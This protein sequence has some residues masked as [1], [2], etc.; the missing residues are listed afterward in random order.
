MAIISATEVGT[1]RQDL[2]SA[3]V[4]ETLKLN[5]K[6]IGLVMD[7]STSVPAGAKS[8]Y[9]P[10]RGQFAAADKVEDTDLTAQAFTF[11]Q[12]QLTLSHKA[13]L[14][15]MELIADLQSAVNVE[16]EIIKESAMEL[17]KATDDLIRTQ[18]KLAS[19]SAPDHIL[20]YVDTATDVIALADIA[21]ARKLLN[22]QNVPMEDRYMAVSAKKEYELLQIASFIQ[23]ERYGSSEPIVNGEIGRI[24]GFKVILDN[25]LA[26]AETL[27]WHK[28]AAAFA[29]QLSPSFEKMMNLPG[30]K[31]Q[32]LL[33]TVA[34]S[35]VLQAGK[36]NVFYNGTGS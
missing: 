34:G 36:C 12:D 17:A 7:Y 15:E 19:T 2:V 33:H 30:V 1:T 14:S 16:A 28:S 32:Y 25:G 23:A 20:D 3:V 9:I 6:Y 10:R 11:T 31:N 4:Q 26:D 35:K 27:F 24:F 21:N 5:A 13:I 8:V 18:L 29:V 22:T